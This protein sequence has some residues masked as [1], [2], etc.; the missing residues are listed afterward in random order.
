M[1][2]SFSEFWPEWACLKAKRLGVAVLK[3]A[4]SVAVRPAL[5]AAALPAA[6]A[7]VRVPS[8]SGTVSFCRSCG[9]PPVP[10]SE[11]ATAQPFFRPHSPVEMPPYT[12]REPDAV[13]VIMQGFLGSKLAG[14]CTMR[15]TFLRPV[16]SSANAMYSVP[17]TL[18]SPVVTLPCASTLGPYSVP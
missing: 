5:K 14:T 11:Y 9:A 15:V 18:P 3:A 2:Q 4:S 8:I 10:L 13:A 7:V 17:A 1:P 12:P 6:T 16:P